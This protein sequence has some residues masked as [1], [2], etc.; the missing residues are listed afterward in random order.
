MCRRGLRPEAESTIMFGG[1]MIEATR[2]KTRRWRLIAVGAVVAVL[3]AE[4]VWAWSDLVEAL[5]E[6]R[7]PHPG[8]VAVAVFAA[9][10]SMRAYARMQ[11]RLLASAG[12][13]VPLVRH[14]QLAYAAH[15]LSVTL[16]G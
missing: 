8:L 5:S 7:S 16:P 14:I 1:H 4:V 13:R 6:L 9:I 2:T 3:V 11:R 15:S 10:L 12:I